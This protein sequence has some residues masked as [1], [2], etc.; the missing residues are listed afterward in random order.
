MMNRAGLPLARGLS[1]AEMGSAPLSQDRGRGSTEAGMVPIS[2]ARIGDLKN[3][4]SVCV[5]CA[6]GYQR[7][8][9]WTAL[10]HG[11][12]L[13]PDDKLVDL[14]RRLRCRACDKRRKVIV[15]ICQGS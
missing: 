10:V 1:H 7:S 5:V 3:G 12:R 6:C 8:I 13:Q 4:D 9:P 15:M 14:P 11:F 2:A